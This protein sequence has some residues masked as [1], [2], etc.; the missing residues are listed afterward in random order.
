M[1]GSAAV[2]Q[3]DREKYA[4]E[5]DHRS[6]HANTGTITIAGRTYMTSSSRDVGYVFQYLSI[7]LCPAQWE[8]TRFGMEERIVLKSSKRI[9]EI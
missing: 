7:N 6:T 1:K 5:P 9:K 3:N 4:D 2:G 8:R